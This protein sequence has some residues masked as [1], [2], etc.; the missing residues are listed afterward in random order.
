MTP[1]EAIQRR[2]LLQWSAF[3]LISPSSVQADPKRN[4]SLTL[5]DVPIELTGNWRDS[6]AAD[7]AAVLTRTRQACLADIRLC[8]DRQPEK[9]RVDDHA[10][11]PPHIWLHT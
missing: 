7:V 8:S 10:S 4:L 2:S 9:L 1:R 3:G 11:G 6:A 5:L